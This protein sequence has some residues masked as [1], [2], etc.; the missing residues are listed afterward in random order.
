[1]NISTSPL[2]LSSIPALPSHRAILRLRTY[3]CSY[4]R[5][6]FLKGSQSICFLFCIFFCKISL[7]SFIYTLHKLKFPMN[8]LNCDHFTQLCECYE[9]QVRIFSTLP[10]PIAPELTVPSCCHLLAV[11]VVLSFLECHSNGLTA[12]SSC[13]KLSSPSMP[14]GFSCAAECINIWFPLM[15]AGSRGMA[16]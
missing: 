12:H 13:A 6:F 15:R 3:F 14:L 7:H 4:P 11:M 2:S 9:D 16:T 8:M 10:P 5:T 1:M